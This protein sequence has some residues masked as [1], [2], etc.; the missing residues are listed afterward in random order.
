MTVF[1]CQGLDRGATISLKGLALNF[2]KNIIG[3]LSF[4]YKC[5]T[6]HHLLGLFFVVTAKNLY[7]AQS[8]G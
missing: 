1:I 2:G 8:S 5:I 3:V 7:I 4:A 6:C